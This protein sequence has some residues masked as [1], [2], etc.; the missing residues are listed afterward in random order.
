MSSMTRN[1]IIAFMSAGVLAVGVGA[2]ATSALAAG[3]PP[4]QPAGSGTAAVKP[5]AAVMQ[6]VAA[7]QAIKAPAKAPIKNAAATKRAVRHVTRHTVRSQKAVRPATKALNN[8][9]RKAVMS[10]N[11]VRRG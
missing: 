3:S 7:K 9:P 1:K 4:A 8:A 5:A 11:A 10:H 6:P 2:G